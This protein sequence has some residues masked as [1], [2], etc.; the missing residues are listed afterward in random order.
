[1]NIRKENFFHKANQR[2]LRISSN[3]ILSRIEN[4]TDT[5]TFLLLY[6]T[7]RWIMKN[8]NVSKILSTWFSLWRRLSFCSPWQKPLFV[9]VNFK[10][11]LYIVLVFLLLTLS[12]EMPARLTWTGV[13]TKISLHD[14]ET[15]LFQDMITEKTVYLASEIRERKKWFRVALNATS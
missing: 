3:S 6:C 14:K 2:P 10:H 12:R 15:L 4:L 5:F 7:E 11:I 1:M 9:I 8:W 13:D